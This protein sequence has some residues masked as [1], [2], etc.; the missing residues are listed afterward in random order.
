[1]PDFAHDNALEANEPLPAFYWNAETEMAC[2]A[3]AIAQTL[4]YGYAHH[5]QRLMVTG[6]YA[7]LFGV[8]PREIHEW[9][10][11]VYVDAFE[12][13]EL[14]N[15]IGMSQHADGGWM[16]TKPYA[17]SGKYIQRMSN[18]CEGCRY[19]PAVASGESACPF[20]T[21]YWDF[22]D[23]HREVLGRNNR[24]ALQVKNLERKSTEERAAIADAARM[25]RASQRADGAE[26][27]D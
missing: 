18:Y 6:L 5:I 14:P 1:M 4:R 12:W 20:T 17:A 2:L 21:L 25:H 9:Y 23:R 24:M 8:R 26:T 19:D 22:L 10:L 7:M 13:V 15:V 3:D 11:A 27:R 16:M